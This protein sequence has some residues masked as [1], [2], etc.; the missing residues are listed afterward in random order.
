MLRRDAWSADHV[1]GAFSQHRVGLTREQVRINFSPG[2]AKE[3]AL[4]AAEEQGHVRVCIRLETCIFF[5]NV[6]QQ[7]DHSGVAAEGEAGQ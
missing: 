5:A 3:G 7:V 6:V 1:R 2:A 4:R